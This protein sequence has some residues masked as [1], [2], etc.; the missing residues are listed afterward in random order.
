[1]ALIEVKTMKLTYLTECLPDY[2][3][4]SSKPVISVPIDKTTTYRELRESIVNE[5]QS[6]CGMYPD[7]LPIGSMVNDLLSN[8]WNGAIPGVSMDTAIDDTLPNN[9]IDSVYIYLIIED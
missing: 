8:V 2:F 6:D 7:N 3:Q 4:G 9:G 1:M 5:Y